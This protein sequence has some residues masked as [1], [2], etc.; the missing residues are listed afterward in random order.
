MCTGSLGAPVF[1]WVAFPVESV[2][3]LG[4]QP[5]RH[6]LSLIGERGFCENCGTPVMWR[7]LKPEPG[8]YLAI[9][10]T[11]LE[12]PEDYAPTWHGGIESQMPW[13]QIHDDLPRARCPESPFLREAWGS[14]GAESPDQWVTLEYEQAKQLA[15][16]TDG[17]QTG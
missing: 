2:K 17:D 12:N 14:M 10:V 16:K 3:F 13:L 6:R 1:A 15:G 8:T 5:R 11:I 7:A 4:N 9:P